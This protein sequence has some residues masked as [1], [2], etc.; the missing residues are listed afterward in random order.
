MGSNISADDFDQQEALFYRP[1]QRVELKANPGVVDVIAEYD[2]M[3]VPPIW[4]VNDPKPRYPHEL[5]VLP[6]LVSA[7]GWLKLPKRNSA[8]HPVGQSPHPLAI[9]SKY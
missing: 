4:L 6:K 3:M 9:A 5:N 8:R 2:P 1:G 7:M